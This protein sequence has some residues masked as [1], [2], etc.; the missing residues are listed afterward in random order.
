[1]KSTH[2]LCLLTTL[3][4]TFT[5]FTAAAQESGRI[6]GK[7]SKAQSEETVQFANI[8]L[9]KVN[10]D[11]QKRIKGTTTNAKGRFR[12][13]N[14][15]WGQYRLIFSYTG[16][17]SREISGIEL[18]PRNPEVT[19]DTVTM[20]ATA[21]DLEAVS[22]EEERDFITQT[23]EGITVNPSKN[24][25]QTGGSAIDIL[26]NTPTVNVTFDGG[27]QMRGTEAGATQV[28]INGRESALSDNVDQIPASAI[29]TIEV[30]QNPGAE[31]Q[32]EGK[33][34]VINIVL[35]KQT[36]KGTNGKIDLSAGSREQYNTSLQ[37]NHGTDNFNYFLNL[38]RQRDVGIG[39]G[40]SRR[41][42]FEGNTT[43]SR[44]V[45]SDYQSTEINNTIRGGAEYFWNY[46]NK[47]GVDVI[48]EQE[49]ET[50]RSKSLNTRRRTAP[51]DELLRQRQ[52]T[53]NED[54][55][56]YTYEPTI[57]YQRKF[58]EE[59]KKLKAS[60]KYS[61]EVQ[62]DG[63]T[64]EKE[65]RISGNNRQLYQNRQQEEE[66]RQLGVFRV[67]FTD[68]FL[69]DGKLETG[70]RGQYRKF[71]NNYRYLEY[72]QQEDTYQNI[73]DISNNFVYEE[74]VYAGYLQGQYKHQ[75]WTFM[76][77]LRAEQTFVSTTVQDTE[78]TNDQQ[79]LN[80]FPSSRIQ[81]KVNEERSF[82]LSYSRRID[83]PSA[84]RLN[85]FPDLSDSSSIF[86]GNPNIQPEYINALEFTFADKWEGIDINATAFYRH[87]EG[88]ID[89]LT[90][91]RD[92]LPYIRPQ[93]LAS[94]QTYGL[95]GTFTTR[96]L[97]FWR[98]NLN[99]ATYRSTISGRIGNY[100]GVENSGE[101]ISNETLTYRAKLNT[102]F[103]LPLDVR[104]QLTA[105][106]DGPEAEARET[107][108]AVY[109]FNA[110]VQKELF[111]GDGSLG[112]NIRDVLDTRRFREVGD[113]ANFYEE[114]TRE[115]LA[116][117]FTVS[118]SY[119]L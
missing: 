58:P 41:D 89:Y 70:V 49:D 25:T 82:N 32:A 119:K 114:R 102:S 112:F 95:E 12:M 4:L 100:E 42:V 106:F 80:F 74:Q 101:S 79:Y 97:D 18:S 104:L 68:P 2:Q 10:A 77:G 94:G 90:V 67:D 16:Y 73:P 3:I 103:R 44:Q 113:N 21:E 99:A 61:M 34:G 8:L 88:V 111:D 45:E 92:G 7:V 29:E 83:R 53:D 22:I 63:T 23:P 38:N 107:E 71:D 1:M 69:E 60:A 50:S 91:I 81:Y 39:F 109:Y 86:I 13:Q 116:Q 37:L 47:L 27:I 35:K 76:A 11:K 65:S 64:T 55:E 54:Q 20:R 43:T 93:N 98:V 85:P 36:Q 24:I 26:K 96:P 28:L 9:Q 84:W 118:F 30:V 48:L 31:Y 117:L 75:D 115:R 59:G 62:D 40:D 72:S 51:Q 108:K 56:G 66:N 52:I 5:T 57:Y 6:T 87:R 17:S 33:G 46:F 15:D 78:E 14:L 105:N 19:L 110:G